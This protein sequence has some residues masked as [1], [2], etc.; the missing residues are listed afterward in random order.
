MGQSQ[1]NRHR[2]VG[3]IIDYIK[4]MLVP[5]KITT[6]P[7]KMTGPIAIASRNGYYLRCPAWGTDKTI[8][9]YDENYVYVKSDIVG[10]IDLFDKEG[11]KVKEINE[12]ELK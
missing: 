1:G 11:V 2:G 4:D 7:Y 9:K 5:G 10:K 6:F 12:D 8:I 3:S